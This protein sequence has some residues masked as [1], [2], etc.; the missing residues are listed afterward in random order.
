MAGCANLLRIFSRGERSMQEPRQPLIFALFGWLIGS[1]LRNV[2]FDG[3]M[4][5]KQ[6]Q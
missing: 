1:G 5:M 6:C 4:L 2:I 3:G